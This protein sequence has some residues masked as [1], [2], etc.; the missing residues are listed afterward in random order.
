MMIMSMKHLWRGGGL[1]AGLCLFVGLSR[2]FGGPT[3][4]SLEPFK[5]LS[6]EQATTLRGGDPRWCLPIQGTECQNGTSECGLDNCTVLGEWCADR[7]FHYIPEICSASYGN[8][9]CSATV[10][11][12]ALCREKYRCI[13]QLVDG[14]LKCRP[15]STRTGVDCIIIGNTDPLNC[16]V[17]DC[18]I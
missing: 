5:P 18:P 11:K 10:E 12:K 6:T 3:A 14:M 4:D 8:Q 17:Q 9:Y 16:S 13:C 15:S 2:G 1:L 7:Y